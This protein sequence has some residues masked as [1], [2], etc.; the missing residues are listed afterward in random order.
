MSSRFS[1]GQEAASSEPISSGSGPSDTLNGMGTV[2]E[3]SRSESKTASCMKPR[4]SA[5]SGHSSITG[6]PQAMRD[7]LMSLPQ[8]SPVNRS[9]SPESNSA[10]A[11]NETCGP[12]QR[13]LFG[14]SGHDSFCLKMCPEY[15]SICPWS[16]EI[17]GDLAMPFSDPSFLGLAMSGLLIEENGSGYML[18]TPVKSTGGYNKSNHPNAKIRP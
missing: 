15:A 5:I 16:S 7:W 2:S 1:Q 17:C 9:A 3:S 18:P 6:T 4:S 14:L 8:D 12:R 11:T 10:R 13:T